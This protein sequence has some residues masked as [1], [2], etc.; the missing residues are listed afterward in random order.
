MSTDPVQLQS[1]TL[2]TTW[3]FAVVLNTRWQDQLEDLFFVPQ[4]SFNQLGPAVMLP[5]AG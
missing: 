4:S 5:S 2:A 1:L 3:R